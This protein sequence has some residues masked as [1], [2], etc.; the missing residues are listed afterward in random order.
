M[1]RDSNI[2]IGIF[3]NLNKPL[4]KENIKNIVNELEKKEI[5]YLIHSND[6]KNLIKEKADL[7]LILG[8]DGTF[9]RAFSIYKDIL[10]FLGINFGKFGFLSYSEL[11]DFSKLVLSIKNK[12]Y[13]VSE[14]GFIEVCAKDGK[15][16]N[17]FFALNEA[18]LIRDVSSRLIEVPVYINEVKIG[19]VPCDGI[20][21]STPTGSTAYNL[22][23]GGPIVD[24]HQDSMVISFM[25]SHSL[26]SR[27]V[28][29]DRKSVVEIDMKSWNDRVFLIIDGREKVLLNSDSKIMIRVAKEKLKFIETKEY[30]FIKIL[31]KKFGWGKRVL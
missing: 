4:V 10:P 15:T 7:L 31:E 6:T 30:S 27:P 16:K 13:N 26:F 28:V 25:L 1:S 23:A 18:T 3:P 14:R 22:S 29:L 20:L 24:P 9:L 11:K 21:V 8:G 2:T 5:K 19:P 12:D 17:I